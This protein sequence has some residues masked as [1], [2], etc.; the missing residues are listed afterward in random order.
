MRIDPGRLGW[1]VGVVWLVACDGGSAADAVPLVVNEAMPENLASVPDENGQYA[2]WIELYNAGDEDWSLAGLSLT[3]DGFVP[4][5]AP[6]PD[7]TVPAGGYVVLWADDLPESGGLHLPFKLDKEGEIL[8]LFAA[9]GDGGWVE[10]DLVS[11]EAVPVDVS[12][13]RS[14]DGGAWAQLT[15]ATPGAANP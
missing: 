7:V 2:D 9:A 13:G 6:L 12:V 15:V 14:P 1:L 10:V 4:G 3:D 11:W 8:G 5:K